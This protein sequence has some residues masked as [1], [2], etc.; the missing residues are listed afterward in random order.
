MWIRSDAGADG[1]DH[2][3]VVVAVEVRVDAALEAHLGGAGVLGLDDPL[4][5]LV[6]LQQVR[7]RRAG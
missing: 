1:P 3:E 2:L 6:E 5:D 7:A 4:G